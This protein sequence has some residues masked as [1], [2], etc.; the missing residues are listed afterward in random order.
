MDIDT[1]PGTQRLA[2]PP[3]GMCVMDAQLHCQFDDRSSRTIEEDITATLRVVVC[4]PYPHEQV[5]LDFSV[6]R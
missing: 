4:L 3:E 2:F 5:P 6:P 1:T